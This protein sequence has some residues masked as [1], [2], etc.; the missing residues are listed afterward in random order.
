M[1][2]MMKS[3]VRNSQESV[4][5]DEDVLKKKMM[6]FGAVCVCIV[7][8]VAGFLFWGN[9]QDRQKDKEKQTDSTEVHTPEIVYPWEQGGKTPDQYTWEEYEKL[10]SQQAEAFRN[11]FGSAEAF[12]TWKNGVQ[13]REEGQPFLPWEQGGKTPDQYTWEEYEKLTSQQAE[14]FYDWFESADVFEAWK[15]SVQDSTEIRE[16]YPWEQSGKAPD[17]YTWEEYEQLTSRQA[18]A[19]YDWFGSEKAFETW[20]HDVGDRGESQASHAWEQG[21]KAP[22]QYTWEEYEQLTSQQAEAF[23][24]WFGTVEAFEIW[25][26]SVQG[27][28]VRGNSNPWE[29]GSKAPDQYTWQEYEQLTP[30]QAEAFY[31]WFGSADAFEIWLNRVQ[32]S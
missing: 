2:L 17:Q 18:E 25:K 10:T 8:L 23:Y 14:A 11:W 3:N 1:L 20:K 19:F 7:V 22:D 28:V 4:R 29:Q 21:G 27:E 32:D 9:P 13:D 24:D 26:N 16:M 12:E 30:Q 31:D 5:K 15:N 6:L